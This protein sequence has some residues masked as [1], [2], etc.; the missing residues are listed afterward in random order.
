M[1]DMFT[2]ILVFLLKA[3]VTEGQLIQPSDTLTLPKSTIQTPPETGLELVVSKQQIMLNDKKIIDFDKVQKQ[4]DY[5]IEPLQ[6]ALLHHATEAKKM[7][8]EHGIPFSGKVT[9]QGDQTIAYKDLVKVMATCGASEYP[10][11]RL[12]VYR[13]EQ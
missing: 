6:Q 1:M 5:I 8:Q 7:Q 3:Y 9:I 10:N 12:V 11:M 2:I 13:K 4:P